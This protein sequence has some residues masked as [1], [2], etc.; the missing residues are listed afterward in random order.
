MIVSIL[1]VITTY[2]SVYIIKLLIELEDKRK[3]V[4]LKKTFKR[5]TKFFVL[6]LVCSSPRLCLG[7]NK[8]D[9]V[10]VRQQKVGQTV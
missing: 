9:E 8:R 6:I 10:F 7:R 1:L 4:S 3:N 2:I 5:A